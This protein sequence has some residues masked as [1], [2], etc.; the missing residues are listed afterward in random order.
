MLTDTAVKKAKAGAKPIRLY[1]ERGLY[2]EVRATASGGSS[3]WW[4]FKYR[5]DGKEKLL[6]L[7]TYPETGLAA[8]RNERDRSRELVSMGVDPSQARKDRKAARAAASLNTFEAV[9][10]AWLRDRSSGWMPRTLHLIEASFVNHVFGDIGGRPIVDIRPADVRRVV[11]AVEASGA[12]EVAGR[13]FQRIR[14]VFRYAVAHEL[15]AA[16]PTYPLKPAE[17][18]R[19]RKVR[20]RAALPEAQAPALLRKLASYGGE[21]ATKAALELLMLTSVRPGEVRGARWAEFDLDRA[22]WRIEGSRTKMK[23]EHLVPL[24]TQAL[25]LLNRMLPISGGRDLVFPSALYPGKPLSENT[26]NG[27]LVR[28]GYEG[29]ATAHGMRTLFSTCANEA[30]WRGELIEK[31]LAHEERDEVRG[32]YNRAAYLEERAKLM[33]WWADYLDRLRIGAQVIELRGKSA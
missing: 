28:M 31:Q 5:F 27:A 10:R 9:A 14:S 23:T 2:L 7:G 24:S 22:L 30:G 8:A 6:S 3:K 32:A 15:V 25:A 13:V 11:K 17:I 1:D 20:H 12:G 16:D 21:P 19:P 33:Q 4:R 18:L 26:L 29:I